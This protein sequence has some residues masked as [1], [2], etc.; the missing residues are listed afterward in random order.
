MFVPFMALMAVVG[1]AVQ[2]VLSFKPVSTG[3]KFLPVYPCVIG[4]IACVIV[5]Y[6]NPGNYEVGY[7]P[8]AFVVFLALALV[9]IVSELAWIVHWIVEKIEEKKFREC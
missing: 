1:F 5:F 6:L 2:L 9:L 4:M 7:D 8:A 3:I